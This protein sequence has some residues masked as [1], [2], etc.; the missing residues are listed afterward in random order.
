[1]GDATAGVVR[2]V[3]YGRGMGRPLAGEGS[4]VSRVVWLVMLVGGTAVIATATVLSPDA[5]GMGTHTQ[6]G[7]PPCGFLVMFGAP[8]PGCGLT[9]SF[10]HMVRFE[11]GGAFRANP[12]GILL[13][14]TTVLG[15][16][17][18]AVGVVRDWPV[19]RTLDRLHF[20]KVLVVLGVGAFG[21]WLARLGI[22]FAG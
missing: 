6:L 11:L 18:A 20:E 3:R 19:I 7:M 10:A 22:L 17:V 9:T 21:V 1:M 5:S 13:F 12:F 15:M 14:V 4:W 8:C 2:P 16:L